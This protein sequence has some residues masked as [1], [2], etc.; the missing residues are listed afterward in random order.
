MEMPHARVFTGWR[1]PHDARVFPRQVKMYDAHVTGEIRPTGVGWGFI[2]KKEKIY[3]I[4][5]KIL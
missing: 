3:I 1:E 5:I 4:S 2:H